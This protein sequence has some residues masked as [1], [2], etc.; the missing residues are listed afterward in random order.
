VSAAVALLTEEQLAELLE[1]AAERGAAKALALRN[2]PPPDLVSGAEMCRRLG[3]SRST[4]HRFR[5]Q[6][7][8]AVPVG[9]VY[10]YRAERVIEWLET[11]QSAR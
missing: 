9:D 3:V 10:R 4:L 1:Q 2:V 11:R 5:Q 6:G 7:A 8:P